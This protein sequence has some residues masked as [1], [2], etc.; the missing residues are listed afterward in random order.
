MLGEENMGQIANHEFASSNHIKNICQIPMKP[1]IKYFEK[2][3]CIHM[4]SNLD[5]ESLLPEL[6]QKH[7]I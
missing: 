1:F 2:S 5:S 6:Q 3:F 4:T 7:V